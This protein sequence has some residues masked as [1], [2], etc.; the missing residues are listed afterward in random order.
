M[1][2]VCVFCG[3]RTGSNAAF[4]EQTAALGRSLAA[5]GF[6]IVYGGGRVGLMGVLAD[7]ALAEGGTVV[8]VIP[9]ALAD[10][11][12]AHNGLTRL[13]VVD[14]M[15][16]RKALMAQLSDT[17]I[18]LPGGYGTLDEFCEIVTWAQLGIHQ[19]PIGLLNV[20]RYY[21]KLI[22]LFD[23]GMSEGFIPRGNRALIREARTIEHL[24]E[25]LAL[26]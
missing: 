6:G 5:R 17:F 18:A 21:D 23:L 8:G 11:E 4:A 25:R 15:H 10:A 24:L 1:K 3:A 2:Y 22:E 26:G 7:A 13:H 20:D 16:E 19:K 12:V 14:S 9:Q